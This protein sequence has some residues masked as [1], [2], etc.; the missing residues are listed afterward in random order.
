MLSVY[1][2]GVELAYAL[3]T[4]CFFQHNEK[5]YA[6]LHKG[7]VRT[8]EE[9]S[10]EDSQVTDENFGLSFTP[11]IGTS[12]TNQ[13]VLAFE[14]MDI[15]KVPYG[16]ILQRVSVRHKNIRKH[17]SIYT[18]TYTDISWSMQYAQA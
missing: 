12:P 8:V 18:Q 11:S 3:L 16:D 9:V 10:A 7:R 4:T 17:A 14:A 5:Q 15:L 13:H 6:R 2:Y 1:R